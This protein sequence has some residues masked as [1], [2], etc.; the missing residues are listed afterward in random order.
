M[1]WTKKI[2][3]TNLP[4]ATDAPEI[5]Q[6]DLAFRLGKDRATRLGCHT[7]P[8]YIITFGRRAKAKCWM[9]S[10]TSALTPKIVAARVLLGWRLLPGE[11]PSFWPPSC[12]IYL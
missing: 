1:I 5:L 7:S 9:A 12:A 11:V 10:N 8:S 4:T 6:D 3:C 2:L